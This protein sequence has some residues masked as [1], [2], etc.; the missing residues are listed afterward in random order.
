MRDKYLY[1]RRKGLET[2]KEYTKGYNY[3]GY[4]R[5]CGSYKYTT[6]TR[7]SNIGANKET[8]IIYIE[9]HTCYNNIK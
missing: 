8:L 5:I 3:K 7:I 9:K 6:H 1:Q 4:N 2:Q